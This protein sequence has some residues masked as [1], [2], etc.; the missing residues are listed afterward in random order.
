MLNHLKIN[1]LALIKNIEFDL[2]NGFC[3]FTGETGAGKSILMDAVGMLLGN[4]AS[5]ETIRSGESVA[6]VVGSF[7]FE[8]IPENLQKTIEENSIPFFDN[9]LIIKRIIA[10]ES[11][12]NKILINGEICSLTVL[13][14]IGDAI[15]D[16]HGQH[17]HQMLLNEDAPYLIIDKIRDVAVEKQKFTVSWENFC[18]AEKNLNLHIKK[19]EE[20]KKKEDFL[21]FEFENISKLEL[22][23][24][25][26]EKLERE[27]LFFSSAAQRIQNAAGISQIL[28]GDANSSGVISEISNLVKLLQSMAN[29]DK[30]FENWADEI[31]PF[32]DSLKDLLKTINKYE[33]STEEEGQAKLEEINDRIAK[34]QKLKKKYSCSFAELLQK[35]EELKS[36]LTNI[37]NCDTDKFELEKTLISAKNE[38]E[39]SAQN[40]SRMRKEICVSFDKS[41]TYEMSK[42]GFNGG[43]FLTRFEKKEKI[44]SK[45]IDEIVFTAK[46]NA[47][48][49]FLPL[50]KTASG[51]EISRIMLAIKTILA[52][53]DTIPIMV[54]DEIDTGIGGERAADIAAAIKKLAKNHQILVISHLHQIASQADFHYSIFKTEISGRTETKIEKLDNAQRVKEVARM[55]GGEN[56]TTLRHAKELLEKI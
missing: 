13:K 38:L 31:K 26:E 15:I 6:E 9:S 10:T 46:T 5:S 27:F 55:L 18:T 44:D 3:V 14:S 48:E 11:A 24:A 32:W 30:N 39:K 53:N 35:K 28:S 50:C 7:N 45:G 36:E 33:N 16:L 4:R 52:E 40:L 22:Q 47:G 23:E 56:E 8:K 2:E 34:I 1:N 51:G 49:P 12:K 41:I 21:R 25:E 42:L 17:D 43:I 54:F 20:L 37:E 19:T 29:I